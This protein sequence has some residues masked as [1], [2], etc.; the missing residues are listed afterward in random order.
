[1]PIVYSSGVS[2]RVSGMPMMNAANAHSADM[3][4]VARRLRFCALKNVSGFSGPK[5]RGAA[6]VLM[7]AEI[8]ITPSAGQ[9][10][11]FLYG[12]RKA[13]PEKFFLQGTVTALVS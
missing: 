13:L 9:A 2:T 10:A 4:Q 3:R 8:S 5:L 11:L 1:M 12:V 7:S 6:S